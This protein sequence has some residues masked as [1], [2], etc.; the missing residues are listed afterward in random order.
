MGRVSLEGLLNPSSVAILG[1][2]DETRRVGGRVMR[3]MYEA[4]FE[5]PIYPINPKRDTVQGK[6]A[7]PSINDIPGTA[8]LAILSIPARF[9]KQSIYDCAAKGVK[10]VVVFSSGFAEMG[11]EGRAMQ[12]ELRDAALD[13]G[14]RLLG[15]NCLGSASVQSGVI[16]S[17]SSNF[18]DAL[19]HPG[20]VAIISQSGAFGAHLYSLARGRGIGLSHWVTTGNEVDINVSECLDFLID[21]PEVNTLVVY[22][23]GI[24]DPKGLR[25]A[26]AKARDARKPVI[27]LKVGRTEAGAEAAKSHTASLAVS[28][29]V[30]DALFKQYGVY[31]ADTTDEMMDVA[32][33]CQM[34]VY[35]EGRRL[36]ILSISGGVGV[37]MADTATKH[38]LQVPELSEAVQ[39]KISEMLPFAATRN[40]VD[41]TAQAVEEPHFIPTAYKVMMEEADCDAVASFF[42]PT[43]GT[44]EIADVLLPQ[45]AEAQ[46]RM[47]SKAVSLNII[48]PA[49]VAARYEEAG[50]T[51]FDTPDRAVASLA[52]LCKIREGFDRGEG[53]APPQLPAGA[54]AV[55]VAAVSEVEAKRV[56]SKAGISVVR[57]MLAV[58]VDAAVAGASEIGGAVVLKIAS[59][60]IQHK[61]EIGGV[62][63][64]V[65]GS[66]AVRAGFETLMQR[67]RDGAPKARLDG[68][69][70]CEMVSGGVE[71]VI[72]V[73]ADPTFGPVVMF[74]LG[75]I[76]VEVLKDVTFRL[77]PFGV[78]EAARMIREIKFFDVLTG[79][80]GGP[81]VDLD[82][83]AETLSR[84][85]VFAAVNAD[86]LESLD[87]NP[88]LALPK[89]GCALDALIV[90]KD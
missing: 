20:S 7:Y 78:D 17:F 69:V 80:R 83:L 62:M 58:D 50:H 13:A 45:F 55:P 31:R 30:V 5:G 14:V 47:P 77:A 4:G 71:T 1:A 22:A 63:V 9:V 86:K 12:D 84:I 3:Y 65:E 32:Y 6:K 51:V 72:G 59:P 90:P 82:D 56:L 37:Q 21:R 43:T 10:A 48:M 35:P 28:D 67:A 46:A 40:P 33:A 53:A 42:I 19:P 52:A 61:T 57:E 73:N 11:D 26:L 54:E 68:V 15:P 25:K 23:E 76:F 89:G 18:L 74:G 79:A 44:H 60:D 49:D 8:D 66:D 64:N 16:A 70:V 2:T 41:V 24:N 75:G 87:I 34:G 27:F 39:N 88:Y 38:G 85:S 29:A 36:G 81:T